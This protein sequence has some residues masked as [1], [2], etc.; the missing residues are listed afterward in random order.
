MF[1]IRTL[2]AASFGQVVLSGLAFFV[3]TPASDALQTA[4]GPAPA[5]GFARFTADRKGLI[6]FVL[7]DNRYSLRVASFVG[8][9][10]VT[11]PLEF[12]SLP[13]F[14]SSPDGRTLV[15]DGRVPIGTSFEY[16]GLH[17]MPLDGSRAP[18]ALDPTNRQA[19]EFL[20]SP[21][22]Q[23]VVFITASRDGGWEFYTVPTD[24]SAEPRRL[25]AP[26]FSDR[27]VRSFRISA[28]GQSVVYTFGEIWPG[29][30]EL[31]RAPID[32]SELGVRLHRPFSTSAS[33]LSFEL[34]PDGTRAVYLADAEVDGVDEL[35][36]VSLDGSSEEVRLH[37][38][39]TG[40]GDVGG[41]RISPDS[42]RVVYLADDSQPAVYQLYSTAIDGSTPGKRLHPSFSENQAVRLYKISPDGR[43]VVYSADVFEDGVFELYSAPIDGAAPEVQLSGPIRRGPGTRDFEIS[44]DGQL[45]VF[46]VIEGF[47]SRVV[48][49]PI[50]ESSAS[51]VLLE[52]GT[53]NIDASLTPDGR[54]LIHLEDGKLFSMRSDVPSEPVL[55]SQAPRGGVIDYEVSAESRH[56]LYRVL[57]DRFGITFNLHVAPIDGS[58]LNQQIN[59]DV[60]S[61]FS[62]SDFGLDGCQVMFSTDL[63][64]TSDICSPGG[65]R[66]QGERAES[67]LSR[68]SRSRREAKTLLED[69]RVDASP[70]AK[71]PESQVKMG[72]SNSAVVDHDRRESS[73]RDRPRRLRNGP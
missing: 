66:K 58:S 47:S 56:V 4:V 10:R 41:F 37:S 21:D 19:L 61:N 33:V 14:K 59:Q 30:S 57:A 48:S 27:R 63:L 69:L 8:M 71:L 16:L 53:L 18:Y 67:S 3:A 70:R 49:S 9:P 73:H 51:L 52:R 38:P 29:P 42:L 1:R 62:V 68:V 12:D 43:R 50:D 39:L 36:S 46:D 2:S 34:S 72:S 17:A 45:V 40:P 32:G 7:E 13:D 31:F 54:W 5:F 24:G 65:D 28:D 64:Y 26:Q 55:L 44:S 11:V 35:Y 20:F 22:G 25:H 6:Y 15:F 23:W 60:L